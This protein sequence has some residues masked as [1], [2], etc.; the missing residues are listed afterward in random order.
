MNDVLRRCL[1]GLVIATA[2]T[3]VAA[4]PSAYERILLPL[5]LPPGGV[6]GA[7]GSLW[8]T[9]V[10][11]R[12]EGEREVAIFGRLCLYLCECGG[13]NCLLYRPVPP[14]GA[15]NPLL[16]NLND[17][18]G[19]VPGALFYVDRASSDSVAVN[20]RLYEESRAS[21]E[22]GVEIPVIR[23]EEALTKRAWLVA[24]PLPADSRAHVRLYALESPTEDARVRVRIY[25]AEAAEP[26][27]DQVVTLAPPWFGAMPGPGDADAPVPGYAVIALSSA[28]G[29]G[30]TSVRVSVEPVTP[31]LKFWMMGSVTSNITQNVTLVTPQ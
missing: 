1:I 21:T 16:L 6:P 4:Q 31:G 22:F 2:A 30:A 19:I 12:N 10:T 26:S 20:L 13:N 8:K 11:I 17:D 15:F 28:M 24:M 18:F 9:A 7:F 25:P 14:G 5:V 3:T 29:N 23:E 27:W